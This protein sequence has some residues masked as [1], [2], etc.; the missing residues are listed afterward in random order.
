MKMSKLLVGFFISFSALQPAHASYCDNAG[1]LPVMLG[2]FAIATITSA[3]T[4]TTLVLTSECSFRDAVL[5]LKDTAVEYRMTGEVSPILLEGLREGHAASPELS[6]E[7]I[8]NKFIHV[9]VQ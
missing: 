7:E 6:D 5:N 4:G 1:I 3:P 9:N 2:Y 8:I